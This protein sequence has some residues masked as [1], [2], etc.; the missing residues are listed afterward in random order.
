M[1]AAYKDHLSM[2]QLLLDR[3]ALIDAAEQIGDTALTLGAQQGSLHCVTELIKRGANKA[4]INN[5]GLNAYD[6]AKQNNH[7]FI[8]RILTQD[9]F[10]EERF[11]F[12]ITTFQLFN[13]EPSN[14]KITE[15]LNEFNA[16]MDAEFQLKAPILERLI[17]LGDSSYEG[18]TM[19]T[20]E[21]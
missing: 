14:V 17:Q 2:L 21:I 4:H 1:V 5:K 3:N 19:I 9:N 15:K 12:P 16:S 20:Y 11:F 8:I 18:E 10:E 7:D 6:R 13:L